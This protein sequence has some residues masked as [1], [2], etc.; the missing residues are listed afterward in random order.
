MQKLNFLDILEFVRIFR[1]IFGYSENLI[2]SSKLARQAQWDSH[3]CRER[4]VQ[5]TIKLLAAPNSKAIR[6]WERYHRDSCKSMCYQSSNSWRDSTLLWR[7]HNES[8]L[9]WPYPLRLHKC[10]TPSTKSISSLLKVRSDIHKL[11]QCPTPSQ[12]P[13]Q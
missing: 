7:A 4:I 12:T 9:F 8:S 11:L 6:V 10:T 5:T 2:F 13:G 3:T 1:N